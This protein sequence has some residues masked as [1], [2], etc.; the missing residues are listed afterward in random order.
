MDFKFT[1]EQEALQE[2]FEQF[3][4][5][6]EKEAPEWWVEPFEA[7]YGS[8]EGW[9]YHR[10]VAEKLAEKNWLSLPWPREYGGW[11]LGH[12]EQAIFSE[13]YS[14]HR[15]PG[16]DIWGLPILSPA[17]LEYG[18]EELKREWLPK[19]ARAETD[20]CQGW[21]E[22]NA[23]SDLASLTTRAVEDGDDYVINGQ[24]IWTTGAHRATHIFL[25]ARTDPNAK[26]H[27]GLTM[28]LSEMNRPG[29]EVRP[30]Y[31]MNRAHV[32]NEVFFDNLRIPRKNIVGQVNQGWH[33]TM[34][35]ANFERSGVGAIGVAQR[36]FSDLVQYCKETVHNGQLLCQYPMI[37]YRLAD[38]AIE[39][40][41]GRQWSYYVA[42]LQSQNPMTVVEAS[43]AKVF[44]MEFLLRLA[45]VAVEIMG[46]YGTLKKGSKWAPLYGKFEGT[47]QMNLG[48]TISGGA[49]EIQK[50]LIAWMG[51]GLPRG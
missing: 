24:K 47:C 38:L 3:F 40:Q 18:S 30:L 37:R 42:W 16:V 1:S 46:L 33:A 28:F 44:D 45:N 8:D 17:I 51:L 39:L 36:D 14:Y 26:R 12:V 23:G 22:P 7:R 4:T 29:I 21:S 49:S 10:S 48:Y 25:L 2:E 27:R 32:Y 13:V 15:S 43:A 50:N 6:V 35:G 11:A 20:W 5:E 9:A 31:F 41:T 34:A 19:I